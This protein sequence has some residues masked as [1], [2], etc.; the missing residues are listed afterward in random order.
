[1]FVLAVSP[2]SFIVLSVFV[3]NNKYLVVPS[4]CILMTI[5]AGFHSNVYDFMMAYQHDVEH[6]NFKAIPWVGIC[7][8]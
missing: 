5:L 6:K 4:V 3:C 1:M 8:S 7:L 2:E